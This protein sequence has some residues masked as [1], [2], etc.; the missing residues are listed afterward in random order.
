MASNA[1]AAVNIANYLPT[2]YSP[3]VKAEVE[4]NLVIANA[5]DRRF[6]RFMKSGGSQIRVPS[7]TNLT[8]N[9]VNV[10]QDT[11]L[12]DTVQNSD[13]IIINNWYECAVGEDDRHAIQD[14][15]D[16]LALAAEKTGY[17]IAAAVDASVAALFSAFTQVVGT[18]GSALTDDVLLEAKGYLDAAD[19]PPDGRVLI[20]DPESLTDLLKIDKFVNMDY[21]AGNVVQTGMVGRIYGCDVL[22]TN[23]LTAINTNYHGACMM[24][25]EAIALCI[26]AGMKTEYFDWWQKHTR[27]V[28]TTALWGMKE[29]RDTFGVWV[30]TRS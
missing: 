18:E 29:M 25:R 3:I 11:T 27:V 6:E 22:M 8:A 19:A 21:N 30:K 24:H 10:E 16:F 2:I 4:S 20:I 1:I 12:N 23:N 13:T 15:P 26:Q 7:L 14:F 5:V 9:A 17:S 28:R